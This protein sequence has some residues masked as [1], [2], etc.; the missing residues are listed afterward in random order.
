VEFVFVEAVVVGQFMEDGDAD[1]FEEGVVGDASVIGARSREDAFPVDGDHVG[2]VARV[3]DAMLRDGDSREQ[4]AQLI[5]AS[6]SGG[7]HD[8][9]GRIVLHV[10]RDLLDELVDIVGQFV[11]HLFEEPI[12]SIASGLVQRV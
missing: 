5:A 8:F 1:L 9:L 11:E 10:E 6:H 4:A 2:Q 3:E 12:E 7:E